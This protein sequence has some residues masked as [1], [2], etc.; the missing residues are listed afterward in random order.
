MS[1]PP[2]VPPLFIAD[3]GRFELRRDEITVN[4]SGKGCEQGRS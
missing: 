4:F 3:E 1:K 2:D